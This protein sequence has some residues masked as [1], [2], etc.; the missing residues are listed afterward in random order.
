LIKD[1]IVNTDGIEKYID[2]TIE[3]LIDELSEMREQLIVKVQQKMK[4]IN[5]T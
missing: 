1:K 5:I 2:E 4:Y 3:K